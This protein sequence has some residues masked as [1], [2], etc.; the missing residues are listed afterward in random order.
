MSAG[1]R[2]SSAGDVVVSARVSKSGSATPQPGDLQ[3]TNASVR[4][5]T[6]DLQLEIAE[7]VR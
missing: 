3:A 1:A 5:G 2:L 6:R 4:V 7:T